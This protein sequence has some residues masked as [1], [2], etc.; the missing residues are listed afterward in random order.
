MKFRL[1]LRFGFA[2]LRLACDLSLALTA[3]DAN[4]RPYDADDDAAAS[5]GVDRLRIGAPMIAGPDEPGVRAHSG[6]EVKTE[7]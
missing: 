5:T 7:A 2:D 3:G 1:R 6:Y 4:F